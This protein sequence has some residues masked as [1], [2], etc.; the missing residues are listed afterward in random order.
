MIHCFSLS[1]EH[2][3]DLVNTQL[4]VSGLRLE[5]GMTSVLASAQQDPTSSGGPAAQPLPFGDGDSTGQ[6]PAHDPHF[7]LDVARMA[8][9][10]A[11]IGHGLPR[12]PAT[13]PTPAGR[14][15]A[16]TC[17]SSTRRSVTSLRGRALEPVLVTDHNAFGYFAAAYGFEMRRRDRGWLHRGRAFVPRGWLR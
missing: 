1:S 13:A 6:L 2:V 15:C 5:E 9:A 7:W 14:R 11:I 4:V 16:T 8:D 3:A 17:S 10:A 12:S